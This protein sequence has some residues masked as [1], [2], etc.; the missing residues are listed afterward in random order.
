MRN[1]AVA[2]PAP[3]ARMK[4]KVEEVEKKSDSVN[5]KRATPMQSKVVSRPLKKR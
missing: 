3:S 4:G 5:E 2:K 1:I